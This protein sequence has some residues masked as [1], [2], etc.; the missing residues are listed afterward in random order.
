MGSEP[1]ISGN[2]G[3]A[4]RGRRFLFG[5]AA[6]TARWLLVLASSVAAVLLSSC[7]I[8]VQE[9]AQQLLNKKTPGQILSVQTKSGEVIEFVKGR[10]A[11]LEGESV[12]G[13]VMVKVV[14]PVDE[15]L[16]VSRGDDGKIQ[17]VATVDG[18]TYEP[19]SAEIQESGLVCELYSSVVIPV[20]DIRIAKVRRPNSTVNTILG[21]AALVAIVTVG[22]LL[23]PNGDYDPSEDDEAESC[24]FVYSYEGD[25]YVLD[26]EPYGSAVC[27]G[28]KR[29]EWASM[30]A[31][32]AVDGEYRVLL[33]NELDETQYTDELKLIAVDH[34]AG[35]H[36]APDLSGRFH[37]FSRP[38][39]PRAARDQAGR[40]ILPLVGRKDDG[41]WVSRVEEWDPRKEEDLRDVLTIE[42]DKPAG[43]RRVKLLANAW[44]TMWGSQVI[45]KFLEVRGDAV[46]DWY[47]DMDVH[48]PAY[49]STV[50]WQMREELYVLKIWVE[51]KDGWKVKGFMSGGGPYVSKDKA[52]VLDIADVPGDILKIRLRP[53]V[54]FWML[55]M[56]AADY[57][58]DL[59]VRTTE[60]A[61]TRAIDQDGRDVRAKLA[62]ADGDY[63]AAPN[64]GDRTAIAFPAPPVAAGLERT[65]F[66][67]ATGYYDV[68][69][70]ASGSPRTEVLER[71]SGEPGFAA[72]FALEEYLKWEQRLLARRRGN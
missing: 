70:R 28:L 1:L 41:F 23:D 15:I 14:F 24:P 72:R 10:P 71:I 33:A 12:A 35:V 18:S 39:P 53:P 36:V 34:P 3:L 8:T 16:N 29:T 49:G 19:V 68:H 9:G 43:A 27:E 44:T 63:L 6:R 17:T 55:N 60:L 5:S 51:T 65:V 20:D 42:F 2:A 59:P 46:S 58:D 30:D 52:Y 62:A 50:N 38:L 7:Y 48:G 13:D 64:R 40:D 25:G 31:I 4:G 61:A 67:K 21:A 45:R 37:S 69:L 47:A 11:H 26:A 54:N 66:V 22:Y 56:L 57:G 32:K